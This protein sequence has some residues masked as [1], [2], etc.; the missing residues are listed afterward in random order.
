MFRPSMVAELERAGALSGALAIWSLWR[1]Y[2]ANGMEQRIQQVFA[3]HGVPLEVHHVSGHAYVPDL[4]R[5]A[6]AVAPHKLVPIHT[7]TPE[8][9]AAMFANVVQRADG[10][11]WDV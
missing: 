7:A 5:L 6:R 1:G 2:L 8:R 3:S 4:Q 9:Y 10:E 11:W